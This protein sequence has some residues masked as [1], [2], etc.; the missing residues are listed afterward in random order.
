MIKVAICDDENMFI[1]ELID[2]ITSIKKNNNYN[3]EICSFNSGEELI[4]YIIVNEIKFDLVFLDICMKEIDGIQTAK[5]IKEIYKSTQIVFLTNSKEYALDGYDV[6]ALDYIIKNSIQLEVKIQQT[7]EYCCSKVN[8]YL[9]INNKFSIEKIEIST[10]MYI[11]SNKRKVTIHTIDYK[12]EIYEKLN[13]IYD[14]VKSFGFT[15]THKSYIINMDFIKK[16]GTKEVITMK[17]DIIPIS[18]VNINI[19]KQD[20][21][22]YL[23][24]IK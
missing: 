4:K 12:Y 22:K 17:G 10:I 19:V 8:D 20:F 15:K 5:R 21:M 1:N 16:I 23:E 18:R 6:K 11:E 2:I 14:K 3:L 24:H 7:L 13:N 9:I